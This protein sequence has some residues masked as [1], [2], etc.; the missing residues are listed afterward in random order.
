M[1]NTF[2][3]ITLV[4]ANGVILPTFKLSEN[5]QH[6]TSGELKYFQALAGKRVKITI[7]VLDNKEGR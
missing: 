5:T 6:F 3:V 4:S 7:Q 1:Q 2:S